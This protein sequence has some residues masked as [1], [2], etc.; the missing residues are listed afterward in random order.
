M[1]SKMHLNIY[2][3]L[4]AFSLIIS[5]LD[6]VIS[7]PA[8]QWP[9]PSSPTHQSPR[10]PTASSH[11]TPAMQIARNKA[12][13]QAE[14]GAVAG[15]IAAGGTAHAV[16]GVGRAAVGALTLNRSKFSEGAIKVV[17]GGS[18]AVCMGA[19][20]A[21]QGVKAAT[22]YARSKSARAAAKRYGPGQQGQHPHH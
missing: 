18:A 10:M 20:C 4:F 14:Q 15:A 12:K 21:V 8:D 2:A 13:D 11:R 6:V 16:H 17:E 22:N 7:V 1:K 9:R 3:F 19:M 5:A